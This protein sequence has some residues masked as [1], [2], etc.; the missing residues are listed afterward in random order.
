MRVRTHQRD[1]YIG[2]LNA[3]GS[4][5]NVYITG[6]TFSPDFPTTPGALD[7]TWAGDPLI[8]WGDAFVARFGGSTATPTATPTQTATPPLAAPQLSAPAADARFN[9]GA[10]ITFD[11]SDVAGANGYTLQ[12]DDSQ[13]FS[14][15]LTRELTTTTS[16]ATVSG[17]PTTRMWWRVRANPN[18]PF[19]TSRRFEIKR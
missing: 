8:F 18:G 1:A 15:P 11:W 2:R 5:G 14:A 6:T 16:Q 12:I 19:S 4:A 3:T 17:L 10:T 7:R 9:P 13:S